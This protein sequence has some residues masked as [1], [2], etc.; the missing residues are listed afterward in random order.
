MF[1]GLLFKGVPEYMA[2]LPAEKVIPD[3]NNDASSDPFTVFHHSRMSNQ[4][5]GPGS[6]SVLLLLPG[7][8]ANW[9]ALD[10]IQVDVDGTSHDWA[11]FCVCH[12]QSKVDAQVTIVLCTYTIVL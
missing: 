9:G 6:G 3:C 2:G 12:A 11:S 4:L 10:R 8:D 7:K 1:K 5:R